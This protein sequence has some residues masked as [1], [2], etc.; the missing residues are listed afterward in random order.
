M[1]ILSPL[2]VN[3][4]DI[5]SIKTELIA[6][7]VADG[8][9]Q[10]VNYEGSNISIL[11]QLGAY[12]TQSINST[13]ALNANQTNLLLSNIRQNIIYEAQKL[14]YNI[15]RKMSAKM[16]V[17]I[18]S[19][20]DLTIPQYSKFTSGSYY[21]LNMTDIILLAG[22][23][24]TVNLVEGTYIDSSI[25]S[26]LQFSPSNSIKQFTLPYTDIENEYIFVSVKKSGET[27]FTQYTQVLNKLLLDIQDNSYFS[28]LEPENEFVNIS[29]TFTNDAKKIT[30]SDVIDV[31]FILSSGSLGNNLVDCSS[32]YDVTIVVNS[33]SSGGSDS[34][35]IADIQ[36]NAPV[37]YNTGNR[38]V[39]EIDYSSFLI[40]HSI[41]KKAIAW[42]GET[43]FPKK[44][45]YTYLTCIPETSDYISNLEE[46]T[47]IDYLAGNRILGT[48]KI[49]KHPNYIDIDI[50]I[51]ILGNVSNLSTKKTLI[52]T[53]IDSYFSEIN[54]F[55]VFFYE[56]KLIRIIE[57]IFE[58]DS[59]ASVRVVVTPKI[60]LDSTIFSQT[61]FTYFDFYIP[62]SNKKYYLQKGVD[63]IDLPDSIVDIETYIVNGWTRVVLP[64]E[65]LGID[66]TGTVN[67]KVVSLSAT[68]T[69]TIVIDSIT[70][71][72]YDLSFDAVVVGTYIK[73]LNILRMTDISADL[74]TTQYISIN[75]TPQMDVITEK[76]TIIQRGTI[77]YI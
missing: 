39:N 17:T 22:V 57:S 36:N 31:S 16:S 13:I 55:K 58:A 47:L 42:G 38:T 69:G 54:N 73:D 10:D 3:G 23:S 8:T 5:E 44:L 76:S 68:P 11:L 18:T 21:F 37:F 26:T 34:E 46:S 2:T 70:Y 74:T 65:D 60:V 4:L 77:N 59:K 7:M 52:T 50:D 75:Y 43:N 1:S 28:S 62:N 33:P 20:V 25:D 15:S 6:Q 29:V 24:Q 9:I 48:G 32:T 45:G 63:I 72:T 12:I 14:G 67:S 51:K 64:E 19:T 71:D 35:P 27:G 56:S 53:N 41:V 66:F 30:S 49:F 61:Q 40:K